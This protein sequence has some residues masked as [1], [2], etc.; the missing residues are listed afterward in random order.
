[1]FDYA[2]PKTGV[3]TI[4]KMRSGWGAK[5]F[6]YDNDGWKD[7]LVAQGHVMDNIQ[8]TQP[9]LRY[10]EPMLLMRNVQGKFVDVSAQSGLPFQVAQAARGEIGRASCRERGLLPGAACVSFGI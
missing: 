8:L 1:M 3:A 9:A 6:D 10:F 2:S 5:F 4:T 7:L